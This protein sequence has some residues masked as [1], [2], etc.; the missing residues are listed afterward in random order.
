MKLQN[1][2]NYNQH[3]KDLMDIIYYGQQ[4]IIGHIGE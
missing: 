4:L 1:I 3:P 2:Q